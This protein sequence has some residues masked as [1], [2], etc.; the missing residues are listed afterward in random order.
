MTSYHSKVFLPP[1]N[2]RG[3]SSSL[4]RLLHLISSLEDLYFETTLF[5][6]FIYGPI[7]D[8]GFLAS[9]CKCPN[10]RSFVSRLSS[11][12]TL[13]DRASNKASPQSS[14]SSPLPPPLPH[15]P[16]SDALPRPPGYPTPTGLLSSPPLPL[17]S[18]NP[19]PHILLPLPPPLPPSRRYLSGFGKFLN[20]LTDLCKCHT[21]R[22]VR[23]LPR[24]SINTS[25][26]INDNKSSSPISDAAR[27]SRRI[28]RSWG[29][30]SSKAFIF[31][32]WGVDFEEHHLKSMRRIGAT[33]FGSSGKDFIVRKGR[34]EKK[35][36]ARF[37][38]FE[39]Q[40]PAEGVEDEGA[41]WVLKDGDVKGGRVW[42]IS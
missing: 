31:V 38:R 3:F 40:G 20:A 29:K 19:P 39:V 4:D 17:L 8:D 6:A 25:T 42:W 2:L 22:F 16:Y 35:T 1:L 9:G 24:P 37:L 26:N 14:S 28:Q 21:Q 13:K 5:D 36:G 33:S 11:D 34:G 23:Q 32:G 12:G 41:E 27:S 30:A 10:W 18:P 7:E 15:L